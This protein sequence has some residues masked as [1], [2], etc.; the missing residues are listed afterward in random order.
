MRPKGVRFYLPSNAELVSNEEEIKKAKAGADWNCSFC[1]TNNKAYDSIC[2]SCGN[3]RAAS[4]KQLEIRE[5]SLNEV[6]VDSS[7]AR[8][9][10]KQARGINTNEQKVQTGSKKTN[11]WIW[12][13]LG[14]VGAIILFYII[15]SNIKHSITV[16]VI[17]THWEREIMT[18][19]YKEVTEEDWTI[20]SGGRQI[21]SYRA[22]HHHRRVSDGYVTRTRTVQEKVGEEQYVCGKRDMGNGYFEDKYCSR[23]V[24][25]SR[26]ETYQEEQFHEEP[27][28]QTK[29]RYAIFKWVPAGSIKT[30]ANDKNP[31]WGDISVFKNDPHRR[32]TGRKEAY[33][34]TVL[35]EKKKEHLEKLSAS[36]WQAINKGDKLPALRDGLGKYRGLKEKD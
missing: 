34:I 25:R 21:S 7:T 35:D 1:A 20:P 32:E 14:I 11:P 16:E 4:D 31:E 19:E 6:P 22:V 15:F 13:I 12:R 10:D 23:P 24:Y 28:Y 3:S 9:L 18:E 30:S 29:Y 36:R 17:Q 5:Y 33:N 27:V 8:G 26:N 2:R